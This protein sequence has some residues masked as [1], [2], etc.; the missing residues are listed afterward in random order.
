[1]REW[2][3][4]SVDP[5]EDLLLGPAYA[6]AKVLKASNLT[7]AD[8]DVFEIHEAFAGQVLANLNAL[9]NEAFGK[10]CLEGYV[11]FTLFSVATNMYTEK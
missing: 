7:L 8:I 3:F 1:M 9:N 11:E 4:V 5:F 6:I 10:E 2:T